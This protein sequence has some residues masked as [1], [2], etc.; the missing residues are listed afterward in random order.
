MDFYLNEWFGKSTDKPSGLRVDAIPSND[1]SIGAQVVVESGKIVILIGTKAFAWNRQIQTNSEMGSGVEW[2]PKI[3]AHEYAHV[4]Q[5][6][7]GCGYTGAEGTVAPKWFF[8]GEAE[9]LSIKSAH[10]T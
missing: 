7:N 10:T 4:Y 8:E 1:P 2:R 9:W 3:P 5:F 6:Q